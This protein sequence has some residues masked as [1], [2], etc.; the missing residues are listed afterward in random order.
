MKKLIFLLITSLVI[1]TSL[2]SCKKD[3]PV[4]EPTRT[5]LLTTQEWIGSEFILYV[6]GEETERNTNIDFKMI[7]LTNFD[8]IMY[9]EGEMDT[10]HWQFHNNEQVIKITNDDEVSFFDINTLTE[11]NLAISLEK[12]D[13]D[14]TIKGIINLTH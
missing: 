11:T 7:F 5:E 6:N 9:Q 4:D 1:T 14:D 10:S 13:G 12:A 2:T 3:C 8:L